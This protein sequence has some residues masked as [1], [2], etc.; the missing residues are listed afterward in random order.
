MSVVH[1]GLAIETQTVVCDICDVTESVSG[2]EDPHSLDNC[3]LRVVVDLDSFLRVEQSRGKLVLY[4]TFPLLFSVR[5]GLR[6][7]FVSSDPSYGVVRFEVCL[8]RD[9]LNFYW[10]CRGDWS[11]RYG[12]V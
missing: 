4:H 10:V 7:V 6:R 5:D 8:S 2:L 9:F 11:C 3:L 1:R 12:C